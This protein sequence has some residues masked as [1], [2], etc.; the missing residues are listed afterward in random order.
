M[1]PNRLNIASLPL[2]SWEFLFYN[3]LIK[4][5]KSSF[6]VRSFSFAQGHRRTM[7]ILAF[8]FSKSYENRK[9]Y[10]NTNV[11]IVSSL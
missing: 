7:E 3:K 8:A 5:R 4:D 10:S 6:L 1:L 9:C 11:A 2:N